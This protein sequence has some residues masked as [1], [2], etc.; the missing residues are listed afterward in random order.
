MSNSLTKISIGIPVFNGEKTIGAALDCL[1][2]QTHRNIEIVISD[3]FS[4]DA[5]G[6]ICAQFAA[7]DNRIKY[8]RQSENIGMARNVRYVLD[9]CD[10]EYFFWNA[11]DDLRSENFIELN[12]DF[13]IKNPDYAASTCPVRFENGDFDT[14]RMGDANLSADRETRFTQFFECW[15][16]NGRFFSLYRTTLL[17]NSLGVAQYLAADWATVLSIARDFKFNRVDSGYVVLGASGLSNS[18]RIFDVCRDRWYQWIFP[19][20]EL[21]LFVYRSTKSFSLAS[22]YKLFV[23]LFG[24]NIA[25]AIRQ[26]KYFRIQRNPDYDMRSTR[27]KMKQFRR[28]ISS[29]IRNFLKAYP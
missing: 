7:K 11:A 9:V 22:R 12:L 27:K 3:N 24:L 1:L 19:L 23:R 2:K 29:K 15:H 21:S 20:S 26:Y 28:R 14:R 10:S 6:E 25:G 4:S 8:F 13:L 5:T 18:L 17:K 16:A